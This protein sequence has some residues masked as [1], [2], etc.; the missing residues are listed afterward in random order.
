MTIK[1]GLT[2]KYYIIMFV[3]QACLFLIFYKVAR[4]WATTI[5]GCIGLPNQK[6][7]GVSLETNG[8][9]SC[10]GFYLEKRNFTLVEGLLKPVEW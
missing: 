7:H 5:T 6:L 3:L 1:Q 9:N 8:L 10:H 4:S 2:F